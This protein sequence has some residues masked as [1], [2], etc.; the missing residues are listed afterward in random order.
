MIEAP[1]FTY[2]EPSMQYLLGTNVSNDAVILVLLQVVEK[3][4]K[5]AACYS[6]TFNLPQRNYCVT[7]RELLA[8][9]LTVSF[10]SLYRYS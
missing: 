4:E 10:F 9:V 6:K 1:I 8:V 2:S 7:Q 3:E 5:A